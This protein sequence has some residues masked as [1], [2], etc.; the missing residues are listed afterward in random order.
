MNFK[1]ALYIAVIASFI[2]ACSGEK[3]APGAARAIFEA[4][5]GGTVATVNGEVVTVPMLEVFAKGRGLDPADPAQRQ[6]ALDALIENVV[7]AQGALDQG[8]AAR[9]EVQAE[10]AL[11]RVQQLAGRALAEH[12]NKLAIGD[13][14]VKAYYDQEAKRTGGVEV[15]LQHLLFADEAAAMA[16]QDRALKPDADFNALIAEYAAGGALQAR[17]LN[18]ANLTQLPPELAQAVQGL[19]D[20]KVVPLPVQTSY[21]W[22][23]VKRVESRAYSPPPFEQVREGARK[24]LIDQAIAAEVKTLREQAKIE[25]PAATPS[26]DK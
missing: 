11:V 18:W 3:S 22:H 2:V 8:I 14:Q 20:G 9:P 24:Q 4:P 21:G 5:A 16:A 26:A 19:P 15:R 10:V 23:V 13:E 1:S 17:E 6:R 12:R 7:L 25:M